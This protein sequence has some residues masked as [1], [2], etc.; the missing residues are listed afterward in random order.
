MVEKTLIIEKMMVE[1]IKFE[2]IRETFKIKKTGSIFLFMGYKKF[3]LKNL[4]KLI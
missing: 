3:N 4:A 2:K 1:V